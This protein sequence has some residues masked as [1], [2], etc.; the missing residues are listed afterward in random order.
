VTAASAERY[1]ATKTVQA[2]ATK[3]KNLLPPHKRLISLV[4]VGGAS[5]PPTILAQS[6]PTRKKK[7]KNGEIA[8]NFHTKCAVNL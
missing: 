4:L 5:L 8:L 3:Y 7:Q 1:L 2:F 6:S